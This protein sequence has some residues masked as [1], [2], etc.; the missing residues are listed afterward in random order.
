MSPYPRVLPMGERVGEEV[1][2]ECFESV[3]TTADLERLQSLCFVPRE[4]GLTLASRDDWIHVPPTDSVGVYEEAMKVGLHFPLHPFVKRVMERFSF[5]LAQVAP[6]SWRYIMGFVCLCRML[7]VRPTMGLFRSCFVLKRHPSS[8]G[9]WY[10]LSWSQQKI[11][12][13]VPSSIHG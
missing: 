6:N 13:G 4:F 9:W 10:F 2:P 1:D 12:L 5:S 11:I 8:G 3:M 7:G